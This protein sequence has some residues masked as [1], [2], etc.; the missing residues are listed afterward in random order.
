[1]GKATKSIYGHPS[2]ASV[3]RL[4]VCMYIAIAIRVVLF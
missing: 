1:M 4:L 3:E 2:M